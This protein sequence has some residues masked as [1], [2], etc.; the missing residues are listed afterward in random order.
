[1]SYYFFYHSIN[2]LATIIASNP[3]TSLIYEQLWN[4]VE[5]ETELIRKGER[6]LVSRIF[7]KD[8]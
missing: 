1:M 2:I 4:D 6:N 3:Q 7:V 8:S 5:G